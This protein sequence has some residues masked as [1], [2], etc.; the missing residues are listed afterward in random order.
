MINKD[1]HIHFI[2]IG[3]IGMSAIAIILAEQGYVISGCDSDIEQQSIKNLQKLG[4]KI[5]QGHETNECKNPSIDIIV[6]SSAIK[7][8][9]PE[10]IAAEKRGIPVIHRS[11]MLAYLMQ[12][13]ESIA[14][15]GSHG[16]TTTSS[17]ISH[18]LLSHNYDPTI[19]IGGH[20]QSIG[21]NG[22]SGNSTILVAEADESDRSLTKLYP[23]IA[24]I[25][26]IDLEHLDTYRDLDD[27]KQTFITFLRRLPFYGKAL[28][29]IDDPH[30]QTIIP[31]LPQK[32][33]QRIVTYG[34][35]SSAD[36]YIS[37]PLYN[38]DNA[39]GTVHIHKGL[40]T[41]GTFTV[42]MPGAHNLLNALAAIAVTQELKIP[43][44]KAAQALE[45]FPGVDRRFT[46]KG[47]YKGA[48]IFDDYGHHPVEINYTLQAAR[49]RAQGNLIVLFQPH[50]Y[51]RTDELWDDFVTVL[52]SAHVDH[53][54]I[55][56]IYSAGEKSRT[57]ITSHALVQDLCKQFPTKKIEYIPADHNF[58]SLHKRLKNTIQAQ[59]LILFLGAGKI[60]TLA[61][62][63]TS[64]PSL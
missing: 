64:K 39:K 7:A 53:L 12:K 28:L 13:K 1:T 21:T 35:T 33:Q 38:P 48:E 60:N 25:T 10:C 20:L 18:I 19:V 29:C 8:D 49:N 56:D 42:A 22:R 47:T 44:H 50:R 55:T 3:G 5:C 59:D 58:S 27:I 62:K 6:Y 43:F 46:Y 54:I 16:K 40:V 41:L 30:I 26:N 51:S 2:G 63:L 15:A 24:V 4:C 14:I 36:I 11:D 17:L 32:L 45:S 34:F 61:Q 9:H 31:Q 52:G 57:N 37:D 23:S